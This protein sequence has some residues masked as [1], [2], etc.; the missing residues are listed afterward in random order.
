MTSPT[1]PASP[2]R[3]RY[4]VLQAGARMHYAV[5][6]LVARAGALAAFYTDLHASHLPLRLLDRVLPRSLRPRPLQRLLGRRLPAD[7]PRRLVR[8]QPLASLIWARRGDRSDALV[9]QRACRERFAGADALYTNFINNDLAV[10]QQ[11]R[12]QGLHVVHELII[13]A[14]VGRIMLEERHLHPGIEVGL[15]SPE[16]VEAGIARDIRKWQLSHRV[17]VPSRYCWDSC[18]ALG[19]DP[20][21]L[22]LVPYGIS[23][24]WFQLQPCPE[25]GRLLFVGQVGL[26]KGSHVLAAACR[27]LG[28]RGT[29]FECVVA[30][31]PIT[32]FDQPIYAG[33]TY[34]GQVPRSQVQQEFRRAD[35]FVLPTL[36][37]SFGLVHLEA[38]ACGVPVITTPHCGAVVRDGVEGF[39]VPIRDPLAL[40]DRI[41]QLLEDRPLRERMG[42]AARLRA[43]EYTWA[44]YGRRLA[45]ALDLDS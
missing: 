32:S 5:P 12:S 29:R 36:A 19:C 2:S 34:L 20:A 42:R 43:A 37:D 22:R 6:A 21:K 31:P 9:L 13:G 44:H 41:Q 28:R 14:D 10:V 33:P 23:E 30:G 45:E 26:R 15:E 17:L 11:A 18:V 3:R 1:G 4:A 8:D 40:A 25:P 35:L 7:L 27:E 38:M 39:L 16:Q 24:H